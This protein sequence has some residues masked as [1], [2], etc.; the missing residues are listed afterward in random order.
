MNKLSLNKLSPKKLSK[1]GGASIKLPKGIKVS[2][3]VLILTS[4]I[5][6]ALTIFFSVSYLQGLNTKDNLTNDIQQKKNAI[7]L[8]PP[9]NLSELLAKLNDSV[10]HL[11]QS[12][13]FPT[14]VDDTK[15]ATQ[16]LDIT[17]YFKFNPSSGLSATTIGGNS[18][19]LKSYDIAFGTTAT[20]TKIMSLLKNFEELPYNTSRVTNL[21]LVKSGDSW[22]FSLTF[23][24]ILQKQ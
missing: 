3:L 12:A 13:P 7:A 11:S 21:N 5:L 6:L 10:T 20:F 24:V 2:Q 14:S 16:V 17:R 19:S 8:N 4:V 18:Y 15:L 22:T 9:I 23:Q 1:E